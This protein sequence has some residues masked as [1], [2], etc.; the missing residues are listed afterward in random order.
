VECQ[1]Q[2]TTLVPHRQ[3]KLS[4]MDSHLVDMWRR[5]VTKW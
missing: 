5:A 3:A 1:R 2:N 4:L